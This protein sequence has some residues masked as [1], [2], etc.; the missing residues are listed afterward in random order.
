MAVIQTKISTLNEHGEKLVGIETTPL[1]EKE[2]YPTVILVHGFGVTKEE[3]GM[4]D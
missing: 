4:F 2:S 1:V 3:G